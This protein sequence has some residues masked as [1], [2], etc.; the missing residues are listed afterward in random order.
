MVACLEVD[1]RDVKFIRHPGRS[2]MLKWCSYCQ[3]FQGETSPY[4]DFAITHGLC[5]ACES[6]HPDVFAVDVVRQSDLLRRVFNSLYDAGRRNDLRAAQR[7]VEDA[8]AANCRPVDILVGVLAPLLYKIGEQW[9]SGDITVAHEHEFT[10]FSE[11]VIDLIER[12]MPR[13]GSPRPAGT[14]RFFLMNAPGNAHT[15]A[16]RILALWLEGRGICV[17]VIVD[18]LDLDG[19]ARSIVEAA[20][21]ALLISMALADQFDSVAAI[22]ARVGA[23]PDGLRPKILVGGYAVKSGMVRFMPGAELVTDISLLSVA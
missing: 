22:S 10:A 20:P 9:R 15:L 1:F 14:P 11:R 5:L 16:I 12:T 19:L 17:P 7:L 23:L 8:V 18:H 21:R 2:K 3:Q 13:D 6:V 4:E